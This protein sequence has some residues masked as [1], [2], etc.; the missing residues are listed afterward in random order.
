MSETETGPN[1]IS[2][3]DENRLQEFSEILEHFAP[4]VESIEIEHRVNDLTVKRTLRLREA[5]S[6]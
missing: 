6:E 5:G 3:S 2:A 1:A 4:R